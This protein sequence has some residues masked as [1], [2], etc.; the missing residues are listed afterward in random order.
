MLVLIFCCKCRGNLC[1]LTLEK[2]YCL[3]EILLVTYFYVNQ[4]TTDN[5]VLPF[6]CIRTIFRA[7]ASSDLYSVINLYLIEQ[8]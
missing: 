1:A 5:Q 3:L 8:N 4:N 7:M 2:Y 6:V